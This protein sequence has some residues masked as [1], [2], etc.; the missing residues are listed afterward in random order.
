MAELRTAE[1][2]GKIE[3]AKRLKNENISIDIII[4]ATGLTK[5]EIE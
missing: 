5:E 1:E 2:K 3:T 4:K